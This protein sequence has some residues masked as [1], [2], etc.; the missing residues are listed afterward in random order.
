MAPK[1]GYSLSYYSGGKKFRISLRRSFLSREQS[2]LEL[3]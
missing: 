3:M 1:S 2:E